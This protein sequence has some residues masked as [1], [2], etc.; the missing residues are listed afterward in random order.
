MT[1]SRTVDDCPALCS[2]EH[3]AARP[4]RR[5][6]GSAPAGGVKGA[7][8]GAR[9]AP[10]LVHDSGHELRVRLLA[11]QEPP[12]TLFMTSWGGKKSLQ[13]LREDAGHYA[14][15]AGEPFRSCVVGGG[16]RIRARPPCS[17]QP[18]ALTGWHPEVTAKTAGVVIS[19]HAPQPS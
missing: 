7:R 2:A 1:Q 17:P 19:R 9:P 18:G 8:L 10:H 6:P 11:G 16:A 12:M 13:E 4:R 3:S 14:G 15:F 5:P